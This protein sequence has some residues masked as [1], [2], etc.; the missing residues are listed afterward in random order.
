MPT[1]VTRLHLDPSEYHRTFSV[2]GLNDTDRIGDITQWKCLSWVRNK[3]V[4]E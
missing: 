2:S 1:L 3:W 4:S